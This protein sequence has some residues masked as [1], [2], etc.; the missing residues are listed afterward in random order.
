MT[1]LRPHNHG[2]CAD[3]FHPVCRQL[4]LGGVA[5]VLDLSFDLDL[6]I[7]SLGGELV[8]LLVDPLL[9]FSNPLELLS[10]WT[11]F[12][13]PSCSSLLKWFFLQ[14]SQ[15]GPQ[16]LPSQ[17]LFVVL[18]ALL[19]SVAVRRVFGPVYLATSE[20]FCTVL[21]LPQLVLPRPAAVLDKLCNSFWN[22]CRPCWRGLQGVLG[23]GWQCGVLSWG[24]AGL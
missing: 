2:H 4:V 19:L 23:D 13:L 3:C 10:S 12:G 7:G 9:P 15:K 11:L 16:G 24:I 1:P 17:F 5:L 22:L 21:M 8:S 14:C 20:L 18:L 6:H